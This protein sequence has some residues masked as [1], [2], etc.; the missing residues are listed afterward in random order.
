MNRVLFKAAAIV[1]I[2]AA[3]LIYVAC[4]G[5]DGKDGPPG[6]GCI[7]QANTATGG[8]DI[9]CGGTVY[10]NIKDGKDGTASTGACTGAP[11]ATGIAIT[12]NGEFV[13]IVSNGEPGPAGPPGQGGGGGPS[14]ACNVNF[15]PVN[16]NDNGIIITCNNSE[17]ARII[18]CEKQSAF[19][20]G[21]E[22][23]NV[24]GYV[25]A[26]SALLCGG[27]KYNPRTQFCQRSN[28]TGGGFYG[29]AFNADTASTYQ[30][31]E[32]NSAVT[33]VVKYL[34]GDTTGI[35]T[36]V[37]TNNAG[38]TTIL[39]SQLTTFL[40]NN[41]LVYSGSEACGRNLVIDTSATDNIVSSSFTP[42]WKK[43]ND[44]NCYIQSTKEGN[45]IS[46]FEAECGFK[47]NA[48]LTPYTSCPADKPIVSVDNRRCVARS[49]CFYHSAIDN[50]CYETVGDFSTVATPDYYLNTKIVKG[51]DQIEK[52][53][54]TDKRANKWSRA[55][56]T[57]DGTYYIVANDAN[58]TAI[59]GGDITDQTI[60]KNPNVPAEAE[61]ILKK[62]AVSF[63]DAFNCMAGDLTTK[64]SSN[65]GSA[66][67]KPLYCKESAPTF[68]TVTSS[69]CE[70]IFEGDWVGGECL[71]DANNQTN[72]E[73]INSA[74]NWTAAQGKCVVDNSTTALTSTTCA[75]AAVAS[76]NTA[77]WINGKCVVDNSTTA[78]TSTTCVV[79]AVASGN[80]AEWISALV[81]AKCTIN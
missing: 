77:N 30:K 40:N 65:N 43:V 27:N 29:G 41:G 64:L 47:F 2:A 58:L 32:G 70:D 66:W 76:G 28:A 59:C 80:T 74:A 13:G 48:V 26:G 18:T 12:C 75:V 73:A 24:Q 35:G 17:V 37:T 42:N 5:D 79:A 44:E 46:L 21:V 69:I 68:P 49:A 78:L 6:A 61:L 7:A 53:V 81:P 45:T 34:C 23:C 1:N 9:V 51:Y 63:E 38:Q 72:C 33:S 52:Q 36:R 55:C 57:K 62:A 25:E 10:G 22:F 15:Y 56:E 39:F 4:S 8:Y 54:P 14:G 31:S 67:N 19:D 11:V 3:A 60:D 16:P 50:T 20:T 71:L